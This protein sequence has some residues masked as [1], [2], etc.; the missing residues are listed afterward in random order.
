MGKT[1][2]FGKWLLV[3]ALTFSLIAALV[4]IGCSIETVRAEGT[5]RSVTEGNVRVTVL[6]SDVIRLELKA[7]DGFT[8]AETLQMAGK[9]EYKGADFTVVTEGNFCVINTGK[10][11]VYVRKNATDLKGS[12][13]KD[14]KTRKHMWSYSGK[15]SNSGELPTP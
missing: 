3:L 9:S 5:P 15:E 7:N 6:D 1:R 14:S 10:Y 11:K 2:G 12:Y 13:I 8:D 4:S